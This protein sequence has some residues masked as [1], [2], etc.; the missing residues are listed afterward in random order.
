M[1]QKRLAITERAGQK[2]VGIRRLIQHATTR[3]V[4]LSPDLAQVAT[5]LIQAA[6]ITPASHAGGRARALD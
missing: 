2:A 3:T 1:P 6:T 5:G 4:T